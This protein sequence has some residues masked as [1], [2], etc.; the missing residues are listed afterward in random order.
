MTPPP[1]NLPTS[2]SSAGE[3][4]LRMSFLEPINPPLLA[5]LGEIADGSL[6]LDAACGIGEPTLA[7][8]RQHPGAHVLGIDAD[9][10][11]LETARSRARDQGLGNAEFQ[12]MHFEDLELPDAS[13]HAAIS[14]LGVLLF[15]DPAGAARELARV[16]TPGAPF[17]LALWSQADDNPYMRL[18]IETLAHVL[19]PR[20]TADLR[21]R[22]DLTRAPATVTGWLTAAGLSTVRSELVRWDTRVSDFDAWWNYNTSAGPFNSLFGGLD[23]DGR[24]A[25]RARMTQLMDDSRTPSGGYEIGSRCLL[26]WG[27]R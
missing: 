3:H 25:A 12:A 23:D 8:A 21:L 11:A 2:A 13:A 6:V 5:H 24:Q 18:G 7:L 27:S 17:S 15:G 10:A 22:F 16:L 4:A 26:V 20:Q 14:R 1:S 9:E 19:P